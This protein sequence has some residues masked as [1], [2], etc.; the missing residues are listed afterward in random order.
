MLNTA[1]VQPA[2]IPPAYVTLLPTPE[3][4]SDDARLT[5]TPDALP[6][7]TDLW[8]RIRNGFALPALDSSLIA[9]HEQWYADRPDYVARMTERSERY[10]YFIVEEVEKR[11]MPTEIALLPMIESAFNPGA[12][13]VASASGIWQFIPSTG[14]TYGLKQNWWY[15]GRRNIISATNS[16]LD[17]LQK[18]YDQFGD[19]QLALAAYNW[20]EGAVERAQEYNRRRG[21]PTDYASLKMPNETRNYVPKLLAVK[22][23]VSDPESFGLTLQ[24][25]PDKPYFTSVITARHIDVKLAA[26]LAEIP[27]EEFTALNPAHNRPVILEEN[28]TVLLPVDKADIFRANLESHGESLVSWQEYKT[29]KGESLAKVAPRFGLSVSALRSVNGLSSRAKLSNGQ[30]LLVPLNGDAADSEFE[31][32][33]THLLPTQRTQGRAITHTVR[34]GETLSSIARRYKVSVTKLRNWNDN[35]EKLKPGQ[36]ITIVLMSR[37]HSTRSSAAHRSTKTGKQRTNQAASKSGRSSTNSM[38]GKH[39]DVTLNP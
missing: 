29:R 15:D 1:P 24:P 14:R 28:S 11:G 26:Q 13:S 4:E 25:I 17:Y 36:Q 27:L 30:P 2:A 7:P 38:P 9:R 21:K 5:L 23:I 37:H 35:L 34:R 33:N 6:P 18:L 39:V 31:A 32:F 19:W 16:A 20:G 10:L 8:Q 3:D 22:N 12:N